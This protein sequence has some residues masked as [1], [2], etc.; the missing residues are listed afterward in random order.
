[1]IR[2]LFYAT[3]DIFHN[4]IYYH[5]KHFTNIKVC[6]TKLIYNFFRNELSWDN[7]PYLELLN[8]LD[9]IVTRLIVE[10]IMSKKSYIYTYTYI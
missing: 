4:V 1:M 3:F 8:F 10:K 6:T 2:I 5:C 9:N 7:H